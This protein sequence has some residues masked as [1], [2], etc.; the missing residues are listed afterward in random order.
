ME[1]D[2]SRLS[3]PATFSVL[4]IVLVAAVLLVRFL[5]LESEKSL[6]TTE[7]PRDVQTSPT[8]L[9]AVGSVDPVQTDASVMVFIANFYAA[10]ADADAERMATYFVVDRR[11][12]DIA[13]YQ[14]LFAGDATTKLFLAPNA[15]ERVSGHELIQAER[16]QVGWKLTVREQRI[17]QNG[18]DL[19]PL[20]TILTLVPAP[21]QTGTW[22][23]SSYSREGEQGTFEALTSQQE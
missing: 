7:Q 10:F 9:A 16:L 4:V 2:R 6:S 5:A 1:N 11:P 22:L 17:N 12:E 18:A 13:R 23:I 3:I 8:T 20:T 19:F 15:G 14:Q 21:N